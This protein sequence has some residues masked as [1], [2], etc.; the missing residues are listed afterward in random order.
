MRP[1]YLH[2]HHVSNLDR[3]RNFDEL[4]RN[5]NDDCANVGKYNEG[6]DQTGRSNTHQGE[7]ANAEP[8]G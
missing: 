3:F 5:F 8:I 4:H 2:D 1:S 6:E 7:V